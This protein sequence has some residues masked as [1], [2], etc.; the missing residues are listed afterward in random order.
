MYSRMLAL[1]AVAIL[2]ILTNAAA[3]PIPFQVRPL[4]GFILED[5]VPLSDDVNFFVVSDLRR[6]TKMFGRITQPD[7]PNFEFDHVIVMA[8]KP[9]QREVYLR[10]LP[11]AFK[12]GNYLEVYC[13][14]E[15]RGKHK[16]PYTYM[17]IAVAAVPK[18][19]YVNQVRFYSAGKKKKLLGV[20][21]YRR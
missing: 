11:E 5:K 4:E 12:A 15:K 6:F 16:L 1:I 19:F 17:P 13:D 20:V 9:T 2:G 10:F 18:F 14:V 21:Q 8:M 3:Q 7:T